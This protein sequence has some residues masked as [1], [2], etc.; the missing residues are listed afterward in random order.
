[1]NLKKE[2]DLGQWRGIQI[3]ELGSGQPSGTNGFN[4]LI[5]NGK[6]GKWADT[7]DFSGKVKGYI[8]EWKNSAPKN[9]GPKDSELKP[10]SGK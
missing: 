8:C 5:L 4:F 2:M 7:T 6:S 9:A 3:Q 10:P 1:M